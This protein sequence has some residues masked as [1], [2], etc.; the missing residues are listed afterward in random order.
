MNT[1]R[2]LA[3][4]VARVMLALLF[5][6]SGFGKIGGFEGTAGYIASKGMPLPQLMAAGAIAVELGAGLLLLVGYKAR[7]AAMAIFLFMIP[8]TL[9]FHNFW[10]APPDKAMMEQIGFLKNVSIMG[11]LLMVWAFGPGRLALG[12]EPATA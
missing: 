6:L 3:V 5:I 11:G 4:L 9:I 10:A 8:T 7:W 2:D 12:G 1:S